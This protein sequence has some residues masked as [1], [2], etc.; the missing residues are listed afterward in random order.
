MEVAG[1]K[2]GK[3]PGERNNEGSAAYK[4]RCDCCIGVY[5]GKMVPDPDVKKAKKSN[6]KKPDDRLRRVC[7]LCG[8][9]TDYF[10]FGCRRFLCFSAPKPGD[11]DKEDNPLPKQPKYFAVNTPVLDTN[12]E[13]QEEEGGYKYVKEVGVWTCYHAAHQ[14]GWKTYLHEKRT[15]ILDVSLGKRGRRKSI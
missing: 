2:T 12:G 1:F 7:K 8:K 13:L 9:K 15:D 14:T 6:A 4:L 11:E 3:T 10:C 5:Y